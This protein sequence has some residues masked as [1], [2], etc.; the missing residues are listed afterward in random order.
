MSYLEVMKLVVESLTIYPLKGAAGI[1]LQ[2]AEVDAR[3]FAGDRRWMIVDEQGAFVTQ[4]GS[5]GLA[6]VVPSLDAKGLRLELPNE[7]SCLVQLPGAEA[8]RAAV[9]VWSD[10]VSARDAGDEASSFLSD[11]LGKQVRLVWMPDDEIRPVEERPGTDGQQVSFADGF[12]FLVVASASLD[13]LNRRLDTPVPMNRFRPNIVIGGASADAEDTW[14]RYRIGA[15]EFT[16]V[17][18]CA[19]CVVTTI[20][21]ATLAKGAEPLKTLATYRKRDGEVIFGQNAVHCGAGPV[22]VGDAVEVLE[23]MPTRVT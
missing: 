13:E 2:R 14:Y 20:D 1:S 23:G 16:H 19:R 10:Q 8:P 3:G 18:P 11:Y 4:R 6:R 22:V 17:K 12:P 7:N 21:Q 5:P 15:I 9:K